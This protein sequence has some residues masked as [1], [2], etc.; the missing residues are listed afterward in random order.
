M[1][2]EQLTFTRFLAAISIVVFHYG[3]NIFPFSHD[4]IN[5]LFKQANIGVSYFF[6]LSGFVMIIAYGN[7]DKIEFCDY[8]KRRF[9]R[10]YPVYFLAII[11]LLAYFVI[12]GRPIDFKGL[13]L[14]ITLI[15]SWFPGF[16]GSFNSPGWSLAVEMFFY[17]SFPF[18]FNHFYKKYDIK[19]LVIPILII[20]IGSQ[21]ALHVLRFSSF[22]TGFPSKSHDFIF[23]F[24]IMHLSEFLIGNLAG[25]LFLK[26]IKSRNYDLPIVILILFVS[27]LLKINTSINFH[28]GML[29]I[30]FVPLIILVAANN[31]FITRISNNKTLVFLGEISYGIYI[32]Q[33][34][35]YTW[36]NGIMKYFKINNTFIIFY[37]T[38]IVLILFSVISYKFLETPLRKIINKKRMTFCISNGKQS[39]KYKGL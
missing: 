6:V 1:R 37:A 28:N 32:L 14:N 13:I 39:A 34:P 21:I 19:K 18:L 15:Q 10:I 4:S 20:F 16:A 27:V 36:V 7:K 11:I 35:V 17:I 26:G 24:P 22:Y 12:L 8:I 25:I 3:V 31:G 29:A 30:F 9:A 5:F 2:L 23:Y 33:K 38:L